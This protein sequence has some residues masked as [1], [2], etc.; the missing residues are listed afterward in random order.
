[1]VSQGQ[2]FYP[3][4]FC[5]QEANINGPVGGRQKRSREKSGRA[6]TRLR[7]HHSVVKAHISR[8]EEHT[9]HNSQ[10]PS[11]SE[12]VAGGKGVS[13]IISRHVL[14]LYRKSPFV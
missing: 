4:D 1:M 12:I 10:S 8:V 2:G 7:Q 11:T 5:A 9:P 3:E 6:A 13:L 14:F